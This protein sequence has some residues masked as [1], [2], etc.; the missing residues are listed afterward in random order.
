MGFIG[1]NDTM[2][3][4]QSRF[5]NDSNDYFMHYMLEKVFSV[6]LFDLP[7]Q[8][9]SE[10]VFD[11]SV[12][13]FPYFIKKAL[14]HGVYKEYVTYRNN[15]E[16]LHGVIDI[17]RH[18]RSNYPY[19]GKI[20]Y[21]CR[22]HTTD[23]PVTELIRHTI[24]FIK[25]KEYGN[26]VLGND[27]DTHN[28]VSQIISVTSSYEKA[29]RNRILSQNLRSRIH[30]YYSEYEPL[31][32]LCVQILNHEGL[33]YGEKDDRIYGVLFD[34]SWLWESY[35][36]TILA[37][38]GYEHS[39]NRLSIDGIPMFDKPKEKGIFEYRTQT[40]YPDFYK[41]NII[42]DAKYKHLNN[43]VGK[44]DLY[45]VITYMYCTQSKY[46]HY[47]YPYEKQIAP[48]RYKLNG[49]GGIMTVI[50]FYVPQDC[51]KWDVFVKEIKK[52]EEALKDNVEGVFLAAS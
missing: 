28:C 30:P 24:E 16:H 2:I 10:A 37:T 32:R 9:D 48:S 36:N 52:S 5:D 19:T 12:F 11:F 46:G 4:I 25:E 38:T 33:K 21:N 51:G 18:I 27:K 35:L 39:E 22:E 31:R 26:R 7:Y 47:V 34:G 42:L 41:A 23:N 14:S 44:E 43:G 15:D 17:P 8:T 13:L 20:A 45:Q 50:P 49:F 40:L 29:Q 3:K 1:R 6:H